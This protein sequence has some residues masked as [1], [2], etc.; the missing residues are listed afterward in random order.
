M[1]AQTLSRAKP[2]HIV[3]WSLNPT[4]SAALIP[5][6]NLELMLMINISTLQFQEHRSHITGRGTIAPNVQRKVII[7]ICILFWGR[8]FRS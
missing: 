3:Q 1:S 4:L 7:S 2:I 5:L 8:F 6:N